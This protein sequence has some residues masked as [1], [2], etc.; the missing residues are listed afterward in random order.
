MSNEHFERIAAAV[1]TL[2]LAAIFVFSCWQV[3]RAL[4]YG[5]IY[6]VPRIHRLEA[7]RDITFVSDPFAFSVHLLIYIFVGPFFVGGVLLFMWLQRHD[8]Y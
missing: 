4:I 8:K 6:Y 1:G 2:V 7:A 5:V 3:A